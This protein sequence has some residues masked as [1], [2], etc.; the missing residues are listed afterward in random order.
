MALTT[1]GTYLLIFWFI[2]TGLSLR[3]TRDIA[4][5]QLLYCA[6]FGFFFFSIFIEKHSIYLYLV[7]VSSLLIVLASCFL[8]NTSS[9][10]K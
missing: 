4:A 5:P 9:S 6:A 7:Y 3:L 10:S 8:Y 1:I 2:V